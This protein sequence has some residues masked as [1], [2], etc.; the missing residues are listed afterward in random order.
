MTNVQVRN[1]PTD[2]LAALRNEAESHGR[3]LQ[4]HLLAVLDEHTSRARRRAMFDELDT[5][6]GDEPVLDT[7]A[8]DAVR[9]D[10][11]ERDRRDVDRAEHRR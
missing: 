7:D 5:V 11:D 9:A 10:R 1:V 3:S 8:A 6:L 2:V 4:Q